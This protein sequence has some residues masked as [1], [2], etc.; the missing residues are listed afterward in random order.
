MQILFG[1]ILL[2]LL[3]FTSY[4][5]LQQPLWEWQGLVRDPDRWWTAATLLDAYYGFLTFYVW[6][7]YKES[8]WWPRIGWF[9]AIMLLGNMA[10]SAYVLLQLRQLRSGDPLGS[11]L[12]RRAPA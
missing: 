6:V 2:S 1:F 11:I 12:L 9:V 3:A 10:M 5:S 8:R 7:F 4:A